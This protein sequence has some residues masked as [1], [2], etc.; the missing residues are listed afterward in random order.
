MC[1]RRITCRTGGGPTAAG[2]AEM[3]PMPCFGNYK[4]S[5]CLNSKGP[6][7]ALPA[8]ASHGQED[9]RG[10]STGTLRKHAFRFGNGPAGG[11]PYGVVAFFLLCR[12]YAG[13]LQA[14]DIFRCCFFLALDTEASILLWEDNASS[15]VG[16]AGSRSMRAPGN[17]DV[18][19]RPKEPSRPLPMNSELQERTAQIAFR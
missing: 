10:A 4:C 17:E 12:H 14:S 6:A 7:S 19:P 16:L 15:R 3:S 1:Q 8:S 11:L 13:S 2:R 9:R 18:R 5:C